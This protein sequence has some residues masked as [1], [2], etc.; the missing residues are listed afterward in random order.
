V[1]YELITED[2]ELN[3]IPDGAQLDLD[4]P[5]CKVVVGAG[6]FVYQA[7][8]AFSSTWVDPADHP[9]FPAAAIV[10]PTAYNGP[11][12]TDSAKWRFQV[13]NL[14]QSGGTGNGVRLR[15]WMAVV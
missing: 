13:A 1:Q 10:T 12:P 8:D 11:H 5:S 7:W 4:I 14:R 15:L 3:A 2:V 9:D 6:A